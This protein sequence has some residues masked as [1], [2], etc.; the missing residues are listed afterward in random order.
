M[1]WAAIHN[2]DAAMVM[3]LPSS[4]VQARLRDLR[5][6]IATTLP[7]SD[8]RREPILNVIRSIEDKPRDD[9]APVDRAQI[10]EFYRVVGE[11]SDLAHLNI[12]NYR[13]WLLIVS[14]VVTLGLVGAAIAHDQTPEFLSISEAHS[15]ISADVAQLEAAGAIGGLLMALFALIRLQVY[16]GP[17]ALPLW[18]ALVRI[19]A[20]GAAALVGTALMQGG[21]INAI[22]P[23]SRSGLLGYAV[24]FGAAPELVLRFLDRRINEATAAARPT[25]DPLKPVPAESPAPPGTGSNEPK[26]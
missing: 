14:S 3:I 26:K 2:A 10:S 16:S 8:G 22:T 20:G 18:Q 7:E 23:Q 19:P 4:I 5:A 12:R 21:I 15:H 11:A 13:N 9:L 6:R 1:A 25:S 17:V 24:L